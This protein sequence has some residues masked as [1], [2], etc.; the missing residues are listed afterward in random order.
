[1]D[2]QISLHELT[3]E[4]VSNL[5]ES[6]VFNFMKELDNTDSKTF[7]KEKMQIINGAFQFRYLTPSKKVLLKELEMYGFVFPNNEKIRNSNMIMGI[8]RR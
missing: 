2:N 5:T 1:M 8:K 6:E 4:I 7:Y 3:I